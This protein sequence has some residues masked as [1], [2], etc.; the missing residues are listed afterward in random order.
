VVE[1]DGRPHR[2]EVATLWQYARHVLFGIPVVYF[3]VIFLFTR[4][5]DFN[6]EVTVRGRAGLSSD[7]SLGSL[8]SLYYLGVVAVYIVMWRADKKEARPTSFAFV[9]H[10]VCIVIA[11]LL[12]RGVLERLDA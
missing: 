4:T 8:Y 12:L 11:W 5:D 6:R 10:V 3:A 2:I 7:W 9:A 1:D